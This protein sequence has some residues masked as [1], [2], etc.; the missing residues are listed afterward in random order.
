M[1]ACRWSRSKRGRSAG[2]CWPTASATCC[3]GQCLRSNAGLYYETHGE[4]VGTLEAIEQ[5]RWLAAT[6]GPNGR[7]LFREHYDWP[8]IERKYLD[9]FE[10]LEEESRQRGPAMEPLPGWFDRRRQ[11]LPPAEGRAR[12]AAQSGRSRRRA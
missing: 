11:N 7:Q 10:R 4:F 8:V 5:N 9:M 6:L 3:K 2:R 12:R 1:R